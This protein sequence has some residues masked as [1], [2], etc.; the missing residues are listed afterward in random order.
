MSVF[1]IR[2]IGWKA[3]TCAADRDRKISYGSAVRLPFP[4][5]DADFLM[6]DPNSIAVQARRDFVVMLQ[7]FARFNRF[8]YGRIF[9]KNGRSRFWQRLRGRCQIFYLPY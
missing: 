4:R 3:S 7:R 9:G 8:Y 5:F 1:H 6:Y 2:A